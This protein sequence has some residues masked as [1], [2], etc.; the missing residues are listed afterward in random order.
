MAAGQRVVSPALCESTLGSGE[1]LWRWRS[2]RGW[3]LDGFVGQGGSV[4]GPGLRKSPTGR[5]FC[6]RGWGGWHVS[7]LKKNFA[8]EG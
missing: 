4:G 8:S 2:K 1:I 7:R 5:N 3:V 6:T